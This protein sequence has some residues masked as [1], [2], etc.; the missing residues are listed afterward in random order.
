MEKHHFSGGLIS[1]LM[2]TSSLIN[3]CGLR[4]TPLIQVKY[5]KRRLISLLSSSLIS[6]LLL[7]WINWLPLLCLL[8]LFS[9][10]LTSLIEP[11]FSN[12]YNQLIPSLQRATL[13]SVSSALFSLVMSIIF[14]LTGW[15]IQNIGFS[16]TFGAI[17]VPL[18]FFLTLAILQGQFSK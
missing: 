5:S 10:L 6:L 14:P 4:Y 11:I 9:Q 2:I 18:L 1:A 3:I 8:F 12:Y 15:L 16:F 13:L 7:T 17:G